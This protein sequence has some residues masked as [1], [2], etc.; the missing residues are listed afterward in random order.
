MICALRRK[1]ISD[2]K[3]LIHELNS[4]LKTIAEMNIM[5]NSR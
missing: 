5:S 2:I 4:Y 1:A 3:A